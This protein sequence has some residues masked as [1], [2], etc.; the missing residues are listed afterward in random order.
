MPRG[1]W[2]GARVQ[3]FCHTQVRGVTHLRGLGMNPLPW[4]CVVCEG[5]GAEGPDRSKETTEGTG[6]AQRAGKGSFTVRA[7]AHTLG[8]SPTLS[9]CLRGD[10]KRKRGGGSPP[11]PKG[12]EWPPA[13]CIAVLA[14][15]LATSRSTCRVALLRLPRAVVSRRCR[16]E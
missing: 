3:P 14:F 13:M 11:A 2:L 15:G 1:S 5:R 8:P 4:P 9:C 7:P 16:R 10:A 12:Q 6:G